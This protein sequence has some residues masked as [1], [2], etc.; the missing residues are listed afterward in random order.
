M[1]AAAASTSST[2]GR[3]IDACTQRL[4][5]S[6]RV[7]SDP[8][9]P[10]AH[11]SMATHSFGTGAGRLSTD[12]MPRADAGHTALGGTHHENASCS[13]ACRRCRPAVVAPPT[14]MPVVARRWPATTTARRSVELRDYAGRVSAMA[15]ARRLLRRRMAITALLRLWRC[16]LPGLPPYRPLSPA[17]PPR[18]RPRPGNGHARASVPV[19]RIVR[20]AAPDAAS[21]WRNH[22]IGGECVRAASSRRP[23]AAH[24]LRRTGPR[25]PAAPEAPRPAPRM[26]RSPPPAEPPR[27]REPRRT[28]REPDEP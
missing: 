5:Y 15:T 20:A 14:T 7:L 3:G 19:R 16:Y 8:R 21:P 10:V 27:H 13:S 11:V 4:T 18:R 28:S 6:P 17:A 26:E 12:S 9:L 2:Q 1:R 25:C 24:R 23:T 22:G